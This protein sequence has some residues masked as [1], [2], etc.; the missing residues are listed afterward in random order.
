MATADV[1]IVNSAFAK[2]GVPRITALTDD[3]RA[4][5]LANEQY[6]KLRKK[7]LS[8]HLW[9]FAMTRVELAAT[10]NE[11]E[12]GFT[13]EFLIPSNILRVIDTD[14]PEGEAWEV[15][16]N[17][18]NNKVIVCNSTTLKIRGTKDI[19]DPTKFPP[20]FEEC[21]AWLIASDL[22]YALT[23]STTV[24]DKIYGAFQKD[25]AE[26]RSLDAQEAG[27]QTMGSDPW[28]DARY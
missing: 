11:P 12:F 5:R 24:A 23:Q 6:A 26:A 13:T 22:A 28:L 16:F 17:V 2:L 27:L 3:V 15:E 1:D 21:F 19:T 4:A 7:L 18:D 20:Y 8:M 10:V 14:L 9:N 25:L